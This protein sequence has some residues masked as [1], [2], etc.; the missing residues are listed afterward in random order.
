VSKWFAIAF[1]VVAV[2]V[3]WA[4]GRTAADTPPSAATLAAAT[5]SAG[6]PQI[7]IAQFTFRQSSLTVPVGTTVTWTNGD[8]DAHT[9]TSADGVFSSPALD[10][11]DA[12]S[13]QFTTP[14]TYTYFCALHPHMTARVI[15]K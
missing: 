8:Q 3:G 11:G 1:V 14:G 12:F 13:Y 10:S 7:T 9:V 2:A 6:G 15:V 5:P 4:I